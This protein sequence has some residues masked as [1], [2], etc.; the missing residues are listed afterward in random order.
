[1]WSEEYQAEL[2][3]GYLEVARRKDYVVGMHVWNFADFQAVQS[4]RRVGGMNL[5]GVFTRARQPKLAAHVLRDYWG[6]SDAPADS[7]PGAASAEVSPPEPSAPAPA[8]APEGDLRSLLVGVARRLDG[9]KPGL[10]TTLK[11]DCRPDGV[12]RFVIENG[13][14]TLVEGDGE[15]AAWVTMEAATALKILSGRLNPMAAVLAGRI[16]VGGDLKALSVLRDL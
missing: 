5:K 16:K 10:T 12:Y 7:A 3:R 11:F 6:R 1:M 4:V 14:V 9:R 15:A 13:A 2:I 8:P